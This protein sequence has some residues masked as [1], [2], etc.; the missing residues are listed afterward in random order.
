MKEGFYA[1]VREYWEVGG[2]RLWSNLGTF[3]E[4][5]FTLK[6]YSMEYTIFNISF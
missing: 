3:V 5:N 2:V 1:A 6:E 4:W